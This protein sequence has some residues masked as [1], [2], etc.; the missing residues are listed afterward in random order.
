MQIKYKKQD[1]VRIIFF[2][3]MIVTAIIIFLFSSQDGK[4]PH[5][6]VIIL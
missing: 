6:Q 5:L 2:V 4:N 1:K 3:L